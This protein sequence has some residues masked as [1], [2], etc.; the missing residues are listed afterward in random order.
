M[1]LVE[2]CIERESLQ[3]KR[4]IGAGVRL[5]VLVLKV[6]NKE[7]RVYLR[8]ELDEDT[9]KLVFL[10]EEKSRVCACCLVSLLVK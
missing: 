5:M 2:R 4:I 8:R 7:A 10:M 3:R 1:G 6:K 9:R